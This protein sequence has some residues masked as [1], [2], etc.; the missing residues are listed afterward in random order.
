MDREDGMGWSYPDLMA[1]PE[2]VQQYCLDFLRMKREAQSRAAQRE[3]K[4]QHG[5]R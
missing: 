4:G 2:Y 1:T 5:A 3:A